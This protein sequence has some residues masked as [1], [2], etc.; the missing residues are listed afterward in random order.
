M[1]M[2]FDRFT[3]KAQEALLRAQELVRSSG[4]AQLDPEHL[5]LA[6]VEQ[7]GGVVPRVLERAGATVAAVRG[8]L[9][10]ELARL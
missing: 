10:A 4:H 5:L 1:A 2:R 7:E 9:R 3:E 8:R 6:L